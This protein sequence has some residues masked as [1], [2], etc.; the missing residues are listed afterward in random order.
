MSYI[1]RNAKNLIND[2]LWTEMFLV[3]ADD[4]EKILAYRGDVG[5]TGGGGLG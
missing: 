3:K 4:I 1:F 5:Q 2:K